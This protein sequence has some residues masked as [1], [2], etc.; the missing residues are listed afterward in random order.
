MRS[1]NLVISR[2][3]WKV[4]EISLNSCNFLDNLPSDLTK[5]WTHITRN[6]FHEKIHFYS[7]LWFH[8]TFWVGIFMN[9][10]NLFLLWR[11]NLKKCLFM[12]TSWTFQNCLKSATN[13]GTQCGNYWNSLSHFFE[14]NFVKATF[15]ERSYSTVDFTKYFLSERDT[16]IVKMANF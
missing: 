14:K 5:Y 15:Y 3:S 16:K 9:N 13:Y 1:I 6:W 4:C 10:F 7:V 12:L 11:K 2:N 8:V